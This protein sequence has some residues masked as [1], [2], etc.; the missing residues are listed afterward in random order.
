MTLIASVVTSDFVAQVSDRRLTKDG[1]PFDDEVNKAVVVCS[2]MAFGYSGLAYLS[3]KRVDDWLVEVL[4][5]TKIGRI[6]DIFHHVIGEAKKELAV[7]P[8]SATDKRLAILVTGW[9]QANKGGRYVPFISTITNAL[10]E[11]WEWKEKADNDFICRLHR[12]DDLN[13]NE[14]EVYWLGVHVPQQIREETDRKIRKRLERGGG[15]RVAVHILANAIRKIAANNKLVNDD[16]MAVSIP[17]KAVGNN[18]IEVS[19]KDIFPQDQVASQHFFSGEDE[20]VRYQ[21][22]YVA[23]YK[24]SFFSITHGKI[25]TGEAARRVSEM[26][27]FD[28]PLKKIEDARDTDNIEALADCVTELVKLAKE[29][30]RIINDIVV[31]QRKFV[32]ENEIEKIIRNLPPRER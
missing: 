5:Q 13:E 18:F 25:M 11:N 2:H 20:G 30:R 10:D 31:K 9:V 21:P 26:A 3:Q 6:S 17:L 24:D 16:L 12:F 8:L 14:V 7:I 32:E 23:C 27:E 15:P 1:K 22:H 28:H 29:N 19:I 4:L